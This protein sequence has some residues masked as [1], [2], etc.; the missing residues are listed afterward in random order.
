M[1]LHALYAMF[2]FAYAFFFR[3]RRLRFMPYMLELLM[4]RAAARLPCL[5]LL[6]LSRYYAAHSASSFRQLFDA[7]MIVRHA[8]L[9]PMFITLL[10]LLIDAAY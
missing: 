6:L 2:S 9:L 1:P 10:R 8:T 3:L 7:A 5:V 4:R